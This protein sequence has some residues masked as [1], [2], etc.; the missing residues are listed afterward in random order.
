VHIKL[1]T[2]LI[3]KE[4][5]YPEQHAIKRMT[6]VWWFG[7]AAEAEFFLS[8]ITCRPALGHTWTHIQ[9]ILSIPGDRGARISLKFRVFWAVAPSSH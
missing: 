1:V 8:I 3:Q 4:M 9:H 2:E 5:Y 7:Y 6:M